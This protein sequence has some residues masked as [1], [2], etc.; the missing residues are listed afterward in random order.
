MTDN[1]VLMFGYKN[2][3]LSTL[4]SESWTALST[5]FTHCSPTKVS[6]AIVVSFH[7]IIHLKGL[8]L[9]IKQLKNVNWNS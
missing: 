8:L 5:R 4:V 2:H 7:V 6:A 9:R 3:C 1:P